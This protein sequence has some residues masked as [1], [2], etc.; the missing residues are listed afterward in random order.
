[1]FVPGKAV[2]LAHPEPPLFSVTHT[3]TGGF[4]TQV[5][6]PEIED[7]ALALGA[8]ATA[9]GAT[10]ATASSGRGTASLCV[11]SEPGCF[12]TIQA[13]INAAGDRTTIRIGSGTFAGGIVIDRSLQITG[14][15]PNSTTIRGG[16]PVV[17]IG[18]GPTATSSMVQITLQWRMP[19]SSDVHQHAASATV[20][21]N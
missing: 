17:T 4:A 1:M 2:Q 3:P 7:P 20:G 14:A 9:T 18:A 16:G 21:A 5:I 15:G 8:M 19:G 12:S 13:A 10:A 11:G 6:C